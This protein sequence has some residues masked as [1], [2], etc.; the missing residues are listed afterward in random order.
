M[1]FLHGK[2]SCSAAKYA[3]VPPHMLVTEGLEH[4]AHLRD[5]LGGIDMA[6]L[7]EEYTDVRDRIHK[8]EHAV[9]SAEDREARER[10]IE[11]LFCA[12]TKTKTL[13]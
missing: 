12:L 9:L 7:K 6:N 3:V 4:S 2:F 5:R 8:V 10:I 1:F 11:E 13:T